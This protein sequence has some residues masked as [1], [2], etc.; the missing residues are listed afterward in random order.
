MEVSSSTAILAGLTVISVGAVL[1]SAA[2]VIAA[3][4]NR[5]DSEAR[6]IRASQRL[7]KTLDAEKLHLDYLLDSVEGA[8]ALL[9]RTGSEEERLESA[10]MAVDTLASLREP[11]AVLEPA[12]EDFVQLPV[13]S[14]AYLSH[15]E[16]QDGLRLVRFVNAAAD[17]QRRIAELRSR[18][19]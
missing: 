18:G 16:E 9:N 2:A 17:V 3:Q 5:R 11:R 7:R 4:Q 15:G 13:D 6:A 14:L 10:G 19:L 8:I 1:F 12:Y